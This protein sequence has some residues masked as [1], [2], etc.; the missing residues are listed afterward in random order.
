MVINQVT[1]WFGSLVSLSVFRNQLWRPLLAKLCQRSNYNNGIT[2]CH[3]QLHRR[4]FKPQKTTLIQDAFS[5]FKNDLSSLSCLTSWLLCGYAEVAECQVSAT[6]TCACSSLTM[7]KMAMTR[8][9][10]VVVMVRTNRSQGLL[11]T[12]VR[13]DVRNQ[14]REQKEPFLP[15]WAR[16]DNDNSNDDEKELEM[17]DMNLKIILKKIPKVTGSSYLIKLNLDKSFFQRFAG[18]CETVEAQPTQGWSRWVQGSNSLRIFHF[19]LVLLSSDFQPPNSVS[20]NW[21]LEQVCMF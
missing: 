2:A 4:Q 17:K 1:F 10:E 21:F 20:F 15:C 16:Q 19:S 14:V 7:L 9:R 5:T 11:V 8:M 3:Q 18:C 13:E 6:S 12:M